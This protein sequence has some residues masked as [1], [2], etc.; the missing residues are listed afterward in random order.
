M[1]LNNSNKLQVISILFKLD[2]LKKRQHCGEGLIRF[3][4]INHLVSLR[5]KDHGLG[6]MITLFRLAKHVVWV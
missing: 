1:H 2:F 6:E 4:H 5:R 3:R